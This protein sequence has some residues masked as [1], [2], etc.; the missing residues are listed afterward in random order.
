MA[1]FY[2]FFC[3]K[4]EVVYSKGVGSGVENPF[5][6]ESKRSGKVDFTS[7]FP[8]ELEWEFTPKKGVTNALPISKKNVQ[9]Q[10]SSTHS[11]SSISKI[12]KVFTV[13]VCSCKS[14]PHS[15]EN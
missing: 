1:I 14:Q 13:P 5:L 10:N 15:Y 8:K 11:S 4:T 12:R 3:K 7:F 2:C 6:F 9:M